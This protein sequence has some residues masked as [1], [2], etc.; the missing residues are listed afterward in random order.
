MVSKDKLESWRW[1]G[2]PNKCYVFWSLLFKANYKPEGFEKITVGRGQLVFSYD[3]LSVELGVPLQT[4]RTTLK[5]LTETGD[6]SIQPTR[7][8]SLLTICEYD[9]WQKNG[10][11]A[12]T[13]TDTI[14]GTL[15]DTN[16]INKEYISDN[17]SPYNPPEGDGVASVS[18]EEFEEL[19]KAFD[20]LSEENRKLREEKENQQKKKS[21]RPLWKD[22]YEEYSRMFNEARDILLADSEFRAKQEG[23]YNNIDYE[24]T[25]DKNLDYWLREDTW[26][27]AKKE[28]VQNIN[29]VQRIKNNFDK[30]R[31]Y[32]SA[33]SRYEEEEVEEENGEYDIFHLEGFKKM[34]RL[35]MPFI[36]DMEMPNQQQFDDMLRICNNDIIGRIQLLQDTHH[37]GSLYDLFK[38]RFGNN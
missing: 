22:S 15:N 32:K 16:I 6:I 14:T 20:S 37:T 21:E 36:S 25:I 17:I 7:R 2:N 3:K 13:Q 33:Y 19:K 26:E 1:R 35:Y 31:I 5:D 4:L 11:Q 10:C 38:E 28:R 23:Y 34:V 24:K 12:N 27:K 30:N 29:P 9:S 8:W 18:L